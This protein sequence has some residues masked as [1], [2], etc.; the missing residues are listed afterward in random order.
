MILPLPRVAPP[1]AKKWRCAEKV[2]PMAMPMPTLLLPVLLLVLLL[3]GAAAQQQNRVEPLAAC[4]RDEQPV[5]KA[6]VQT[7]RCDAG[8]PQFPERRIGYTLAV[9]E[10]CALAGGGC[11]VIMDVH[12][13]TMSAE[14]QEICD[15]MR[16]RGNAAGFI[17]LQPSAPVNPN[18]SLGI[19]SP[20]WWPRYH[21]PQLIAFLRH[22]V[23]LFG[24]DRRRVHISGYS[25]GGFASWNIL[26]LAPDLS[27][28]PQT[29]L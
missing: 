21:H 12:G 29:T 4:G 26:C 9:P 10:H 19:P 13:F 16:V 18:S 3:A 2:P 11:G 25:Q 28:W 8:T 27:E 7:V 22:T 1:L 5:A 15:D 14:E 20:D 6:G 17:V 24:A 23:A